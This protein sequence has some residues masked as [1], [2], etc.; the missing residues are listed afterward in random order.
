[1]DNKVNVIDLFAG[2]GGL[3]EGFS[4]CKKDSPFEIRMSVEFEKNAH[5]TLTLRAFYRKLNS[6]EKKEYFSYVESPSEEDK[7]INF[8]IMTKKHSDKWEAAL[9]ETM[10]EPQAL[11]NPGKW[12]KIKQ[13]L[14]LEKEDKEDTQHEKAIFKRIREI[15]KD[16]EKP[17]IV[18]GG[19]PCQAYSVNGR[20][21][22]KVEEGY[23]AEND[24]RFFLY[25]EYL[26][27]LDAAKPDLFIMENVEGITSAKLASGERIFERIRRELRRPKNKPD[28]QYDLYSLVEPPSAWSEQGPIYKNDNDYSIKAS[29]FGVPQHRK[30]IIL[31]GILRKHGRIDSIMRPSAKHSA[32]ALAELIGDLPMIRSG[33]SK[34]SKGDTPNT[35]EGWLQN[36]KS[37]KAELKSILTSKQEI[38]YVAKRQVQH[39]IDNRKNRKRDLL[40]QIDDEGLYASRRFQIE[41]SF[42]ATSL[43][44]EKLEERHFPEN[45]IEDTGN[46][47]CLHVSINPPLS[48]NFSKKYTN[49]SKWL[50][51]SNSAVLNHGT[52]DHMKSDLLRYM[53]CSLWAKAHSDDKSPSPNSKYFPKAL[54]PAHEN[55]ETGNHA[56]R[57]RAIEGSQV[58]LTITSHLRKDGHA[59]IHYDPIQN[60]SLTVREAARIQTF[61]DDYY[62]EGA[63]GWQF[64]Q[65]GN[66]VPSYLAKKIALH[67]LKIMEDKN[68]LRK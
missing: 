61:P 60:R 39:E 7:N 25:Q 63:R 50:K 16:K 5:K 67:V 64:Q 27:V 3:G 14:P 53:F 31:L 18:I 42:N 36:W 48:G 13:G 17:L 30:R 54:A 59:Q 2:P 56:D 68:I 15:K 52:R 12:E 47:F 32:P 29:D 24:E 9:R 41:K 45:P 21:R 40:S 11:G 66:A 55:W 20:N 35:Y 51:S 28:E 62:F 44:I 26:K 58:P 57:F 46:D 6:R 34:R 49:L 38:D 65:V 4:N 43:E 23:T 22:I 1:M 37:N 8:E 33:I 10:Y 19:P